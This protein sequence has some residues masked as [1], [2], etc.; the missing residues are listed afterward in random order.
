MIDDR[1]GGVLRRALAMSAAPPAIAPPDQG[2][3]KQA[4]LRVRN[5]VRFGLFGESY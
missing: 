1:R 3:A 2:F 5:T 4:G